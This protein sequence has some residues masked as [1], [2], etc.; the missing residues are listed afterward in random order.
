MNYP[1]YIMRQS[2]VNESQ[3]RVDLLKDQSDK[4]FDTMETKG[5]DQESKHALAEQYSMLL[6]KI[7]AMR[8]INEWAKEHTIPPAT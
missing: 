5:L 1:G 4:I 6:G 8:E 7:M 3:K 2:L